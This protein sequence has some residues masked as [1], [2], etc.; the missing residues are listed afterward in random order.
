MLLRVSSIPSQPASQQNRHSKPKLIHCSL[1]NR[2]LNHKRRPFPHCRIDGDC[3]AVVLDDLAASGQAQAGAL[4]LGG[5]ERLEN[6][7]NGFVRD[8]R[9]VVGQRDGDDFF[10][11]DFF[12]FDL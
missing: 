11:G 5:K 4:G 2:H 3:A 9:A 10:V 7:L 8:A 1:R 6:I 12:D